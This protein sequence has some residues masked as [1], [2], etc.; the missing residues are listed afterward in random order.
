VTDF[1]KNEQAP[2]ARTIGAA[3]AVVDPR[4]GFA[5]RGGLAIVVF[6][7]STGWRTL[8]SR[9]KASNGSPVEVS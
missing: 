4:S 1:T 7:L 3:I 5:A 8:T 9:N 6:H 2:S